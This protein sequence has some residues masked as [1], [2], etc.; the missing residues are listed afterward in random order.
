MQ[1]SVPLHATPKQT[2][3]AYT[4][5][6]KVCSDTFRGRV[7]CGTRL[8]YPSETR[9]VKKAMVDTKT[10]MVSVKYKKYFLVAVRSRGTRSSRRPSSTM[11]LTAQQ[12][13]TACA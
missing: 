1:I 6:E 2:H 7:S 13:I 10:C 9:V 12:P 11:V 3:V 8:V 4:K 5:K